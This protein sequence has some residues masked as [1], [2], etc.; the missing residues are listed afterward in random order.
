MLMS[1]TRYEDQWLFLC[2]SLF[3]QRGGIYWS[4]LSFFFHTHVL[5][6][7]FFLLV[8]YKWLMGFDPMI[9]PFIPF[10]RWEGRS[11]IWTTVHWIF[12]FLYVTTSYCGNLIEWSKWILK[13]ILEETSHGQV[14]F[15]MQSSNLVRKM[16]KR[17]RKCL[18]KKMEIIE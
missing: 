11:I 4:C 3:L 2:V 1:M 16:V 17:R 10:L 8:S 9:S 15:D 14:Q 12:D 6:F 5:F 18:G 13:S 7:N